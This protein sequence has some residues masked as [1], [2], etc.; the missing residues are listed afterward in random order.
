MA[1]IE[2]NAVVQAL[3]KESHVKPPKDTNVE[4]S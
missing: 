1:S 3:L 2:D 4:V